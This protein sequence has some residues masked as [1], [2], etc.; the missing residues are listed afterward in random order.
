MEIVARC[1]V[2]EEQVGEWC[3]G[4]A[5]D[6]AWMAAFFEENCR[7]SEAAHDHGEE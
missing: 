6:Y 2:F 1:E 3:G 5:Y 4:F 7:V